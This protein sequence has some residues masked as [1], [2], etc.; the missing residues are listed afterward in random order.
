MLILQPFD[1][2]FV[3]LLSC[4][5][6]ILDTRVVKEPFSKE[7]NRIAWLSLVHNGKTLCNDQAEF[8]TLDICSIWMI[9][10]PVGI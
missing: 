6:S 2:N 3:A 1:I 10:L 7:V 5:G 8:V 9:F 4:N